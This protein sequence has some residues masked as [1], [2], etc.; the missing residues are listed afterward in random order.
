MIADIGT[1][2]GATI[3]DVSNESV[4][5]N[6]HDWMH[7]DQSSFPVR[8]AQDLKLDE[9]ELS[10]LQKESY[11]QIHH[12]ET[13]FPS[14]ELH[15]RYKFSNYLINPNHRSF[16]CVVRILAYVIRFCNRLLKKSCVP[17]SSEL[18]KHEVL[19]AED[20]STRKPR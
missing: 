6:G 19:S 15:K 10:Q 12:A 11:L 8:S 2:K 9:S 18:T 1:R 7:L 4:W 5:I 17:D 13:T 14:Q 20:T 16:S 3:D